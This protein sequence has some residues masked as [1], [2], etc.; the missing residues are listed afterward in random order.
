METYEGLIAEIRAQ[1][2]L[3]LREPSLT[4]FDMLIY[5]YWLARM[6]HDIPD[7][8][9][10]FSFFEFNDWL[11]IK[12]PDAPP[13]LV[14]HASIRQKFGEEAGLAKFFELY[15]EFNKAKRSNYDQR[16]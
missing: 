8:E 14:W 4:R 11:H 6:S 7:V 10:D 15:D 1:P 13:N 9:N 3:Y 16:I 5:G 2:V 12:Y